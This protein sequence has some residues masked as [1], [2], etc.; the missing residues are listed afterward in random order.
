MFSTTRD[1]RWGFAVAM[2]LGCGAP[3]SMSESSPSTMG[4]AEM[5]SP[6][7]GAPASEAALQADL[8]RIRDATSAYVDVSAALEQGFEPATGSCVNSSLGT[9]GVAYVNMGRMSQSVDIDHPAALLYVPSGDHMVLVGVKYIIPLMYHGEMYVGAT[10]PPETTTF[11][12]SMLGQSFYGPVAGDSPTQPWHYEFYAW[13]WQSN[14]S[15][16]FVPWNQSL[17][18]H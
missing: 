4:A 1:L 13:V 6:A 3:A 10:P 7:P 5:P 18:C 2:L 15:G 14:P 17:Y 11:L 9:E 12:P 8:Q 16:P